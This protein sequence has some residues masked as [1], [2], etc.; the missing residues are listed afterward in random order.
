MILADGALIARSDTNADARVSDKP[1]TVPAAA[2]T[3][4][5]LL[6]RHGET[7]WNAD[8]RIQGQLDVPLSELGRGQARRLARRFAAACRVE[9][10]HPLLPHFGEL[11]LTIGAQFCS[12]LSRARET[13][14]IVRGAVPALESVPL[15]PNELLRERHFG[16]WQGLKG[17][18]LRARRVVD[19]NEPA[20]GE[21]EEQVFARMGRALLHI[22]YVSATI[23]SGSPQNVLVYGHGGSLRAILCAAL[24]LGA[25]DMRRFRLENTSLSVVEFY[26]RLQGKTVEIANGRVVCVNE[27]AHLIIPV[28]CGSEQN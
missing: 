3:L 19:N 17:E 14:E 13:G 8:G 7:E 16:D 10:P 4:T 26:A 21:T 5:L 1:V 28:E 20:N 27:T 15:H 18:E 9:Q 12:D 11:P 24:S 25:S 22:A 23:G 2:R 6:I